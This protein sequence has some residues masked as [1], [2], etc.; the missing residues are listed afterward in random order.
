MKRVFVLAF[1]MLGLMS[2]QVNAQEESEEVTEEEMQRAL[3]AQLQQFPGQ[4]A[5]LEQADDPA[6]VVRLALARERSEVDGSAQGKGGLAHVCHPPIR[7]HRGVRS[8]S[9]A[10][11]ELSRP[12]ATASRMRWLA[13][14]SSSQSNCSALVPVLPSSSINI[15]GTSLTAN[16]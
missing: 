7:D 13:W 1:L 6:L 3:Y 14:C 9:A 16:L 5:Q 4:Q 11:K 12:S 2:V 10:A 8:P 15:V